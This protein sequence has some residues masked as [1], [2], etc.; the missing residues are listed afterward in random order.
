M[1]E[2]VVMHDA[3]A[4]S[5]RRERST[6][7]F[8]YGD[9]EAGIAIARALLEH[10]GGEGDLNSL[11]AWAGHDSSKSGTFRNKVYASRDFGLVEIEK[12]EVQLTPLGHDIV[13]SEREA[14]ARADAFLSVPLYRA[15]YDDLD[16]KRLPP[17]GGLENKM[18]SLGV[19]QKQVAKARQVFARSAEQAGF[20]TF[21]RDRLVKPTAARAR[22]LE[23]QETDPQGETSDSD[24]AAPAADRN[25]KTINIESGGDVTLSLT[26]DLV[27]LSKRDREFVFGLID[28]LNGYEGDSQ[29]KQA[30]PPNG[31]LSE[32]PRT[33]EQDAV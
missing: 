30:P 29:P 18:H 7:A 2:E 4:G 31:G 19:G 26:V 11:A 16:G 8:P 10:G 3:G 5:G 1:S 15:I 23:E 17:D 33:A 32:Q 21:G 14:A 27:T 12:T 25:I 20:F 28:S 22:Q 13:D 24:S 9:L 6:I